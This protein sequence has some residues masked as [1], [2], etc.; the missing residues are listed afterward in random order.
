MVTFVL[1]WVHT[2]L[3]LPP[4]L[5][6]FH[7]NPSTSHNTWLRT[8]LLYCLHSNIALKFP[9]PQHSSPLFIAIEWPSI[10]PSLPLYYMQ[11]NHTCTQFAIL[12]IS[13]STYFYF[14]HI[15]AYFICTQEI[16]DLYTQFSICTPGNTRLQI[17]CTNI[18]ATISFNWSNSFLNWSQIL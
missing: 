16:I 9:L 7:V 14:L 2:S 12:F 1:M 10:L 15:I 13:A 17:L 5:A 6:Y 18:P 8:P 4:I 3:I 11:I